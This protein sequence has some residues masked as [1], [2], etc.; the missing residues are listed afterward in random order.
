MFIEIN[1][2]EEN[3]AKSIL[4][5]KQNNYTILCIGFICCLSFYLK[6]IE[7]NTYMLSILFC[8]YFLKPFVLLKIINYNNITINNVIMSKKNYL[9]HLEKIN[10]LLMLFFFITESTSWI[11]FCKIMNTSK[12]NLTINLITTFI[13]SLLSNITTIFD[14]CVL[15]P[16]QNYFRYHNDVDILTLSNDDIEYNILEN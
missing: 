5:I 9:F 6:I 4:Y 12:I 13:L 15:M 16:L 11:L 1:K 2:L 8:F 14:L 3:Y 10:G 7:P